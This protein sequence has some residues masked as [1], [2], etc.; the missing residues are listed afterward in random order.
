MCR[1][2]A[3]AVP[4]LA[5]SRNPCLRCLRLTTTGTPSL[6]S[7]SEPRMYACVSSPLSFSFFGIGFSRCFFLSVSVSF[8]PLLY[9]FLPEVNSLLRVCT[10]VNEISHSDLRAL[11]NRE[12]ENFLIG[13]ELLRASGFPSGLLLLCCCFH[14]NDLWITGTKVVSIEYSDR[15]HN[16]KSDG[17]SYEQ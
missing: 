15:R 17:G 4:F 6:C 12:E 1:P 7:S 13:W 10:C 8:F 5:E 16:S 9:V 3:G 14:C 2:R 11:S